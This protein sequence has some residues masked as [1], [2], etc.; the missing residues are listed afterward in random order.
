MRGCYD[1]NQLTMI[2]SL[3]TYRES[4][5][6]AGTASRRDASLARCE[7]EWKQK[8]AAMESPEDK[9]LALAAWNEGYREST[10]FG[11]APQNFR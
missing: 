1:Q 8:A 5:R 10:G 4:G 3:E 11:N 9:P 2:N 7:T 6:K